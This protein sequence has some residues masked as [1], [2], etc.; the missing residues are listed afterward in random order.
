MISKLPKWVEYGAFI[1]ALTA[2]CINAIGLMGFEHQSVSHLSG[3]ATL[4]GTQL[5]NSSPKMLFH[6][7][8][9]LVSFMLGATLSGALL[10]GSSVKLG[11]HY[12]TLLIIE[13]SLLL[14]A[15]YFLQGGTY[16]GHYL[17][18]AACGLQNALATT[19]SGAIVRTTH[20]T[21]IFT[22][23]GIMLGGWFKGEIFDKRKA[24]LFLLIITGFICGGTI[25]AVLFHHFQFYALSIPAGICIILAISYRLY[26]VKTAIITIK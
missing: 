17:A 18:S 9:L 5:L 16:F 20:V 21:G 12:D 11:R 2:G 1:L 15:I 19:Y 13:A 10:S 7:I 14:F 26:K 24:V 4:V 23:L 3:T 22:D 6:L 8:G 25:G